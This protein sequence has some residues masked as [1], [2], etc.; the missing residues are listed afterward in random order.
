M[1][2]REFP[3]KVKLAAFKRAADRCE[4]CAAPLLPGRFDYDH[5]IPDAM[6]GEPTLKNCAILCKSCHGEKTPEDV[7]QIAKAK[8]IERKHVGAKPARRKMPYRKF[9]GEAVWPER[10]DT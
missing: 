2:R 4:R 10:N 1:S 7:G 9:N 6:G 5:V 8:R 3:A